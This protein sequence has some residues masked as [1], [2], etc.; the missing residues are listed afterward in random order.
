MKNG[1]ENTNARGRRKERSLVPTSGKRQFIYYTPK[2]STLQN[3]IADQLL[4]FVSNPSVIDVKQFFLESKMSY[5]EFKK[6]TGDNE[7]CVNALEMAREFIASRLQR[8]WRTGNV[9]PG[10]AVRFL[11]IYD[12]EFKDSTTQP[13]AQITGG[14][15]E[16]IEVP[17]Y[18]SSDLVPERR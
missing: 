11:R 1:K 9:D 10:Y 16:Y 8:D 17:I 12:Q 14:M 4:E 15:K 13:N 7:Y 18:P 5:A 6:S 2:V 3:K